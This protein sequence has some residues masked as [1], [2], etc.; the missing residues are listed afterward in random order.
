M[1][2][3]NGKKGYVFQTE[4]VSLNL[5]TKNRTITMEIV[6]YIG[7]AVMS[8]S[9]WIVGKKWIVPLVVKWYRDWRFNQLKYKS[10]LQ[11]VEQQ[12]NDIYQSQIKFLNDEINTLQNLVKMKSEELK[13]VYTELSR[14]RTKLK[15]LELTCINAKEDLQLFTDNCC[16]KENCPLRVPCATANKIMEKYVEDYDE[17]K[18]VVTEEKEEING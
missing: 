18:S 9:T 15:D 7:T 5:F 8:V 6:N 11:G 1:Q 16:M 10:D 12:G 17:G 4:Y 13:N 3:F 2:D 14:L